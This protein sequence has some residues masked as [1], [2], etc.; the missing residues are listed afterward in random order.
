MLT[1]IED[2][3][4]KIG[5]H[6]LKNQQMEQLGAKIIRSKLLVGDYMLA[7]GGK[8]SI[9]TKQNLD[10]VYAN[11]YHDHVR[12]TNEIKLARECDIKLIFLIEHGCGINDI[13]DVETWINPL[14][15]KYKKSI[16]SLLMKHGLISKFNQ[17][18]IDELFQ[19]AKDNQVKIKKPPVSSLQM[20]NALR[21]ISERYG[22]EFHF[23][24]KDETG[25][26]IIELLRGD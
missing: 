11:N 19:I 26:R 3:G 1:I 2:T 13:S 20:A 8:I 17:Y 4:Q 6:V 5:Q 22:C 16:K 9:D 21:T 14:M 12:F 7:S 15:D 25:K 24:N 18:S 23:C 10:E